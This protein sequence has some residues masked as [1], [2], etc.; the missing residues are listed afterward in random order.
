MTNA[1]T[2]TAPAV[3]APAAKSVPHWATLLAVVAAIVILMLPAQAGLSVAGQRMLAVLAFAVV[4]WM[5]ASMDYAV[6]S[7]VIVAMMAFLLGTS[8]SPKDPAVWLGTVNGLQMGLAGFANSA[9]ALV[10]AALFISVAMTASGLD[11]RIALRTLAIIGTG[12]RSILVSAIAIT[13]LLSFLVPSATARTACAVP[14]MAGIIAAFG[15]DRRSV[16]ASSIMMMVAQATSVWNVGIMTSAAQNVLAVGFMNRTLKAA[17]TWMDWL[18]AGMPWSI[19]MS[20]VL[21]FL[22]L[23]LFPP[24]VK[25]IE[26]GREAMKKE[27]DSLGVM[28]GREWRVLLITVML[29]GFWTTE[30][31]LH[32]FDTSSV[33]IVGV[34]IMLLPG[35]GVMTWKDVQTKVP[36]GTLVVFGV[37]ISLGTALLETKAAVWLADVVVR[38]LQMESMSPLGV[39]AALAAF[40]VVIHLGFASATSL[41]AAMIPIMIAV[42][43]RLGGDINV[44]GMTML[45][46]FVVSFGFILPLNAPQNMVCFGTETFTSKQFTKFG[47][48][49]TVAGFAMLM[50][51][52]VTWWDYLGLLTIR[53]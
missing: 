38:S 30:K 5:A 45:L 37:G 14:I 41:A 20:V 24:D 4:V 8:P 33:T 28:T 6:S 49:I 40:L 29:L 11:R 26:G 19:A 13:V 21:Y 53:R 44:G 22:C 47:L 7:V 46:A 52:A 50:I 12:P 48:L 42:L 10:G 23:W 9:L 32:N 25:K 15:V 2:A 36:W 35:I 3:T 39:F 43:Q 34:A 27:L 51:F 18:V 17:P 1:T 16:F 31:T